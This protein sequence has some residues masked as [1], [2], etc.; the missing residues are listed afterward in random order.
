MPSKR[1]PQAR[2]PRRNR[3]VARR[4]SAPRRSPSPR[5]KARPKTRT[6]PRRAG[7]R[8]VTMTP[9]Q[10]RARLDKQHAR[11]ALAR[12]R[13][14]AERARN[15]FRPGKRSLGK[16]VMVSETGRP[17][18]R[19]KGKKGFLVYVA[20]TGRKQLVHGVGKEKWKARRITDAAPPYRRNLRRAVEAFEV[21]RLELTAK[22]RTVLKAGR[23]KLG[24][25]GT[26]RTKEQP[27]PLIVKP[28]F[29]G[30]WDFTPKVSSKIAKSIKAAL[31]NQA[32]HRTFLVSAMVLVKT[33]DGSSVL[34]FSVPID[35]PDHIA[36]ELGGMQNF[37]RQ[38]FYAGM[39]RGLARLGFVTSG[40]ANNIRLLAANAN[41]PRE[42]WV[43]A[44]GDNW[45]GRHLQQV[46]I[47]SIE[48]KIEQS[49]K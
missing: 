45:A 49:T 13:R 26:R 15:R 27:A 11:E 31:E 36:I 44:R 8:V 6:A 19:G 38:S 33:P 32:S 10:I 40:S 14:K 39:A 48:W 20:K 22:G 25:P 42:Q 18:A 23:R 47:E 16:L 46:T 43:D 17:V 24:A 7:P 29:N 21:A 37:V 35:K 9:R 12:Q 2:A 5:P 28:S 41:K 34:E 30:G 4:R 1:R 3:P